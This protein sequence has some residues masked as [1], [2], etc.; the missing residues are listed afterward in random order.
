MRVTKHFIPTTDVYIFC[1]EGVSTCVVPV[2]LIDSKK[3]GAWLKENAKKMLNYLEVSNNFSTLSLSLSLSLSLLYNS[4]TNFLIACYVS[5]CC[6]DRDE[7]STRGLLYL[8]FVFFVLSFVFSSY[9]LIATMLAMMGCDV[10]TSLPLGV[11]M[12]S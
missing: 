11:S 12:V 4:I 7:M 3:R 8:P 2:T 1:K 9:N 10:S 5:V 6:A